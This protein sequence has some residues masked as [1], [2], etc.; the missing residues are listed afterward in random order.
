MYMR[1]YA[2]EN[3]Q[4]SFPIHLTG[5]FRQACRV[6]SSNRDLLSCRDPPARPDPVRLANGAMARPTSLVN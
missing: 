3:A 5:S 6:N 4:W 2:L 1:G